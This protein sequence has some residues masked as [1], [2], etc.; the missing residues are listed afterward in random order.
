MLKSLHKRSQHT[1]DMLVQAFEENYAQIL[2]FL[3]WEEQANV[4]LIC[5]GIYYISITTDIWM[6]M[7]LEVVDKKME[8]F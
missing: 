8:L 5:R 3:P 2:D 6:G 1:M 7:R 4:K